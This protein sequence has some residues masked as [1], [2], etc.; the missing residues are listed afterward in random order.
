MVYI[1]IFA[2]KYLHTLLKLKKRVFDYF[3]KKWHLIKVKF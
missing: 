2:S 3:L 1:K